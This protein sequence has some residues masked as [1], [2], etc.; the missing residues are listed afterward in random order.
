MELKMDADVAPVA[1]FM[2]T[3][4]PAAKRIS[5]AQRSS[6]ARLCDWPRLC[7]HRGAGLLVFVRLIESK[8]HGPKSSRQAVVSIP[9]RSDGTAK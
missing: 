6:H 5:V 7:G 2:Q 8:R 1:S 3:T 4:L 9:M